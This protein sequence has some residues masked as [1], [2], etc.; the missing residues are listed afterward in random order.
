MR[1]DGINDRLP[2]LTHRVRMV[3]GPTLSFQCVACRCSISSNPSDT[4]GLRARQ[5]YA[6]L[7]GKPWVD[8]YCYPCATKLGADLDVIRYVVTHINKDGNRVMSHAHQGRN[9]YETAEQA[10]AWIE[11]ARKN[12]SE[13]TMQAVYGDKDT[14]EVRAAKCYPV[15]FDPKQCYFDI[16]GKEESK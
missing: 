12:N 2:L 8:Y 4:K 3:T 11:A 15:H 13:S 5:A 7:D 16:D 14:L 10:Q 6:D 1:T 9:T